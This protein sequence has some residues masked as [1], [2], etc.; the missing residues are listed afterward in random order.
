MWSKIKMTK[1]KFKK[2][3]VKVV[4]KPAKPKK[5]RKVLFTKKNIII[6]KRRLVFSLAS[7]L[8]LV[9]IG[10]VGLMAWKIFFTH[11]VSGTASLT[12]QADW[13]AG[14]YYNGTFDTVSSSGDMSIS[15]GAGGAW[16]SDTP[17]FI[18]DEHGYGIQ[19]YR[20]VSYGGDLATDGT[21]VYIITGN[22]SS[23]LI[24]YNPELNTFK[25]LQSAPTSFYYGGSIEYYNGALYAIN[26]GLQNENGDATK[27]LYKY[28]IATDTWSKLADAPD[29]FGL[30]SDLVSDGSGTLYVA[31]GIST[32]TFWR[33]DISSDTWDETMAGLPDYQI[34]TTN[35]HALVYMDDAFGADPEYCTLGCIFATRGNRNLQFFMYD[36][37]ESQWYDSTSILSSYG[38]HY[39]GAMAYDSTTG[40]VFMQCGNNTDDF[41][42][43]DV[44]TLT[45]DSTITDTPDAPATIYGGGSLINFGTYLYSLRGNGRPEFWRYDITNGHWDS[46]S[47]PSNMGGSYEGNLMVY[48]TDA[49]D[50]C[51]DTEGCLFLSTGNNTTTFL[52][53]DIYAHAWNTVPLDPVP[54]DLRE[55]SSIC[56]DGNGTIYA[57]RANNSLSFY[58]YDIS[59]DDWGTLTSMPATH[60][61]GTA[62]SLNSRYGA[63]I[64]CM[65][66]TVYAQKGN[67]N[68]HMF[69]YDGSWHEE[70]EAPYTIYGGGA[71]TNDDTYTYSLMG[72]YRGEF[73]RYEPGVE[74]KE[75]ASLP[76]N[77]YYSANLI[78]DGTNYIYAISGDYQ[79]Y[80]WRY[81]ISEDAWERSIDFPERTIGYG[82]SMAYDTANNILYAGRGWNTTTIFKADMSTDVYPSSVD[83]ISDTIDLKYNTTWETLSANHPTPGS[84]SI[85]FALRT[86][87]DQVSWSSWETVVSEATGDS[88]NSL[89]I[90]S[91]TTPERR[92]LQMK[93]TLTSDGT[94]TPTIEDVDVTYTTD[95]DDPTNPT[96]T[97]YSDDGLGTSIADA[98]SSHHT[99]PYF[100][101]SGASDTSSGVAGYYV[102][103]T[104]DS[105]ADPATSEDYYQTTTTYEVNQE[106]T[107]GTTYYLRIKTKDDADNVS[108][109]ST[110]FTYT[111]NGITPAATQ[112]W[113]AQADFE[114]TGTT[115]T[116]VNTAAG[117]GT[118]MTLSSISGGLWM[119][120]PANFGDTAYN[121][122]AYN[123]TAIAFDGDDTIFALRSV[124]S[125]DFYKYTISTKT[126]STLTSI[127]STANPYG[128]T[129]IAFV[130]NGT[131]CADSDGCIFALSGNNVKE[132]LRYDV[133]ADTWT[134]LDDLP[135]TQVVYY[136]GSL[137]W[138]GGDYLFAYPGYNTDEFYRYS[139]S[140]D[141]WVARSSPD[142]VFYYGSSMTYV[143]NGTYCSDASG[144]LFSMRGSN[145]NQFIRYDILGN[146]WTNLTPVPNYVG[147]GGSIIYND[148]Y[149]YAKVGSYTSDFLRYDIT[150]DTWD[151]LTDLPGAYIYGSSAGMVYDTNTD[152][153]YTFRGYGEYS[154]YSYDVANDKWLSTGLPQDHTSNGFYYGGVTYDGS[155]TL[156]IARGNNTTDF[157]KYT[158]STQTYE[159]LMQ[160][161][162]PMYISSDIVYKSGKVYAAGSYNK[163]NE[164]KM[165]IY[166]VATNTWSNSNATPSNLWLGYGANLVDGEDGYIYTARGQ[167][168]R[169]FLR[170]EIA[171]GDWEQIGT[172]TNIP[173]N[174]YQGGCAVKASTGGIDYIYM[175]RAQNTADIF[176]Y[177]L[178][179]GSAGTWD[180]ID[181]LT[182][183]PDNIYQTDACAYDGDDTIYVPRGNTDN[184]DFYVYTLSTDTWETGGDIRSTN[185]EIWYLGALETGTNGILY[186]FRGY[187]T[188]AMTRYVPASGST[189][190][191][192]NG[193]WTSQILDLGP[194]HDF[195]GLKVNDTEASDTSL[196]YETRTCSD[197]GCSDDEDDVNWSSWTEVSNEFNYGT[198]DYYTIDSTPAQ[199]MQIKVTFASDQIYSPTVNDITLSYYSD[200]TAPTNPS[201][202]TS[203]DEA[204]GDAI[205]T[206]NWYNHETPYF[207]WTGATD[208]IGGI[209]IEGYYVYFGPTSD[210]NPETLGTLQSA[211]TYTAS[212][213]STG[214]TYYL[215]IK[216]RDYNGN[217]S[218]T[219]WAPFVYSFDNVEPS[220]PT[221][222]ASSPAVPT[223]ENVFNF[224][225][226]AGSD[227]GG[228]PSFEY[229]YKRYFSE[230]IQD[231][232][233]TC[234]PSSQTSLLDIEALAEGVNYLRI[235]TRDQA[236]NYS[237]D[238]D[239]ESV[240]YRWAQTPP[241][242]P[243][244][245]EHGDVEGD[246]YSHTFAWSEPIEHAFDIGSYCYQINA[247]PTATYCNL[248]TYG[249]WTTSVETSGR[250][251]AAFRTPNTQPGTN[252]FYIIAKDEAGLADWDVDSF[253]CGAGI[254]CIEF[255]SNTISPNT[256]QSFSLADASNR[257][258]K[259]YRLTLGWKEPAENAG[260]VL[261]KYNIYRSSDGTT[262]DLRESLLHVDGQSEY[263]YTD[264]GL[265]NTVEYYYKVTAVDL[266]GAESDYTTTLSAV[267]EG[268][269]TEP[270][271]L[272]GSPSIQARIRSCLI[273]WLTEPSTHPASS[274]V[275]YG[276]TTDYGGEQGN[277]DLMSSHS[278]TI[279]DLEPATTYHFRL[280]WV[281]QDGNIGYSP[282]YTFAT[283]EA[284]SAPINLS[285]DP[286]YNTQNRFTFDWEP[287]TD[288]G[289][290]IDGYF[291]SVNNIPNEDNVSYVT[292]SDLGPIAAATQQ[293]TNTLYVIAVDDG[294]NYSY[295]NY[296]S[297]EFEVETAPPGEPQ[298]VT[299]IDSSD[300]NAKRYNITLTWDAPI[301]SSDLNIDDEDALYYTIY[302]S[303]DEGDTYSFIARITS[304]GYLDTALDN[305]IEYYYKVVASDK[306]GAVS[307]STDPVSEIPEGRYTEPPA[308]T[309]LPSA[310]P[311]S[312][313][314]L[315]KWRTEREASSFV[316][317]GLTRDEWTEEQG[318][319]ALVEAHSTKVTGLQPKTTYY[320]QVKSID[321][322]ENIA[323]SEVYSFVTLEAPRVSEVAISDIRLFDATITWKTNKETTTSIEYGTTTQ[324]GTTYTDVGGS[325]TFTHTVKL[326][327][328]TD[329]TTYHLK[330]AGADSNGNSVQSDNYSFTTL[331]FPRVSDVKFQN[332]SEG[333]T[334]VTWTTNVPTTST[335][336]YYS[337][338]I[339]SKTQGNT[340]LVNDHSIL[341]FGLDDAT[342]YST[343]IRGIDQFG[344]EAV[345]DELTFTTLEDTT[346]PIVSNVKSESNTVGSG[347]ASKIQI[348]VSWQTNEPT[349]SKA[350][351]GEGLSNDAYSGETEENAELVFE[352][353]IVISG[354]SQARTYHFRVVSTDKAGNQTKSDS[355]SVLTSR[356]RESFLQMVVA[357]LEST[358]SWLGNLG[359]IVP[360]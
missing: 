360:Q 87:T 183:A 330:M 308:I 65:G 267:P 270:P 302:R 301:T 117:S 280:K 324:Y 83:W 234:I 326:D 189:G 227:S 328:L 85:S 71:I 300:R 170:Y 29:T 10:G 36:I 212:S 354:L 130:P 68:N 180:E 141:T 198:T 110:A 201:A 355:Y 317:F 2:K 292:D 105:G 157:Y 208:N 335:V 186:G 237:N 18:T 37:G 25:F 17:G 55:G 226:T 167:N 334:E 40:Y 24:R 307:D 344:Y 203:L 242:L 283:N 67:N 222:L 216:T 297:I 121:K 78:Y 266:A 3:P 188:S 51:D 337:A 285:V 11:A 72:Y 271:D 69:S 133:N 272:V 293:G 44:D 123:D 259:S 250:F 281:D 46:I 245:V 209:G 7:I 120:L 108:A 20:G 152:I 54:G 282:D 221:N 252:T 77:T 4:K 215:R 229:C 103:W 147:Y 202:L 274:F 316:T 57:S 138:A 305:E 273:E 144:C 233:D 359:N 218:S 217:I 289:V 249:R 66:T 340:A 50:G 137:V 291:Y 228:S 219:T 312:F 239:Y 284:P 223:A 172:S 231:A 97:G 220:R 320:Y 70:T 115:A 184:T 148:G 206:G 116:N 113:T 298:N 318:T 310:T 145:T 104:T 199:Y 313:S 176:R 304:T 12:S 336:E 278:V 74:W 107:G 33:Y 309:E 279:I 248:S 56:Y 262:Y 240:A 99:N 303:E 175:I 112:V 100:V 243:L 19:S 125:K 264:V 319:A 96:V 236:G 351:Y 257:D 348:I 27:H 124:N 168:T 30:G 261:Y 277:S 91:I 238:G 146:V 132:F 15:S 5:K 93:V 143:P 341:L 81:S 329:G 156:Y 47:T 58:S 174:I 358:F 260:S 194:I 135:S 159:R 129:T 38:P 306:A 158:I 134:A 34:Y 193:T 111:Y 294:G 253:D 323:Y 90:S 211:S 299:I 23:E 106:L 128:G 353:L 49:E 214:S 39:G 82:S 225:W 28:D 200:G 290:T 232:S 356:K 98:S 164:S 22:Y 322:D 45:W 9:I 191:E 163:D 339:P 241:S 131:Q 296:A 35:G 258:A 190:F 196:K 136:G 287:P 177:H 109:A 315:I 286:A 76:T 213:L 338:D 155:D 118:N 94:N 171:S 346:P 255:E 42:K 161:P 268:K 205:T 153:I 256:P 276:L 48:V 150:N 345:S 86:S 53:Y 26:G 60:S 89:D 119:D 275:Q 122:T 182:D 126:W 195:G 254:G 350:E 311:D 61:T 321:I 352:H 235:R 230:A 88:T 13:E 14:D 127:T 43:Y 84:S 32:A 139:I 92:Y 181:E 169:Y 114:A 265:S 154:F 246:D 179:G 79:D 357:D 173:A 331:T 295:S 142:Q 63:G 325:Y 59:E 75:M 1:R 162:I 8:V 62:G 210:A 151:Y 349:T 52:R 64:T 165:Y 263:A 204:G 21:Y 149:L 80:F 31:R 192:S 288:E 327:K 342:T 347:D 6:K 187:N 314:A 101:L 207:S 185:D 166:D 160:V 332:K 269:Y 244:N 343:K 73:W 333:E 140:G 178:T 41:L 95:S 197:S 224:F 247:I 251:L 16:S 102:L